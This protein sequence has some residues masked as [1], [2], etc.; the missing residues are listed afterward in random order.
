MS[1]SQAVVAFNEAQARVI[2]SIIDIGCARGAWRGPDLAAIGQM[3]D[4]INA[5][6]QAKKPA[7]PQSPQMQQQQMQQQPNDIQ[8]IDVTVVPAE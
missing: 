1:Q 8:P 5:H 7:V 2:L 4:Y 6:L 3:Y